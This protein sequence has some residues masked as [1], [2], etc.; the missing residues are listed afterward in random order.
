MF[1][2]HFTILFTVM[3]AGQ[4]DPFPPQKSVTDL[5]FRIQG[6]LSTNE[7]FVSRKT[8]EIHSLQWLLAK[9]LLL[10]ESDYVRTKFFRFQSFVLAVSDDLRMRETSDDESILPCGWWWEGKIGPARLGRLGPCQWR[11]DPRRRR[12]QRHRQGTLRWRRQNPWGCLRL[13]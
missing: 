12:I 6:W 2:N 11:R 4:T 13:F 9:V 1:S 5:D 3:L 8:P 7:G 10:L